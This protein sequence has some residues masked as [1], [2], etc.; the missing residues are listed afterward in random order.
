MGFVFSSDSTTEGA[1][2]NP[3]SL[4]EALTRPLITNKKVLIS[5]T[6]YTKKKLMNNIKDAYLLITM[7]KI[8]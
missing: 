6:V 1:E 7:K 8:K 5:F 3:S 4:F 2:Q